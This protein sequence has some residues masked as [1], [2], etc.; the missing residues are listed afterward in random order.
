MKVK[1]DAERDT[2]KEWKE[3][4]GDGQTEHKERKMI[5]VASLSNY[6]SPL[7]VPRWVTE[8]INRV[9]RFE[10]VAAISQGKMAV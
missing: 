2:R 1:L 4:S 6:R 8:Y 3:E 5:E 9:I 7:L 10:E